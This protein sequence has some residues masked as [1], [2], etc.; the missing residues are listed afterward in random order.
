MDPLTLDAFVPD[1]L[2]RR[3]AGSR[4]PNGPVLERFQAAL[5][6]ADLSGFSTLSEGLARRGPR[7]AED[8]KDLLNRFFGRLVD[9]VHGHGGQVLTFPG[10]AVLALWPA[11]DGDVS[12]AA[13]I[14]VGCALEAQAAMDQ[15][16]EPD[17]RLQMRAG[18]GAG[19]VW[20][21][22]LGG[23]E[24][25]WELLVAGNA[26]AEALHAISAVHPGEVAVSAALHE[27]LALFARAAR[28]SDAAFRVSSISAPARR[29]TADS[30]PLVRLGSP[31]LR[32]Y[33][34]RSVQA[35]LDAGQTD[36]LGEFRRVSVL[37]IKLGT[38]D[39]GAVDAIEHLQRVVVSVQTVVYRYGGAIN[40]LLA[41]DNGIVIVSGWGFALHAHVDD[42]VRAV[43]TALDLR[44]DLAEIGVTASFGLATGEVFTGLRGNR[45]RC[46]YAMIGDVVNVAARLMQMAEDGDILCDLLSCE[47]AS[48]RIEFEALVPVRVKGREQAVGAYRPIQLTAGGP[49]EIVGRVE[50]RRALRERL[51]ALV[52][53]S[54]GSVVIIEGD[55]GIGK[56]RVV[57]DLVERAVARGVRTVVA[58]GDEIERSTPYH[59]WR[60]LFEK[61]LGVADLVGRAGLEQ[62]VLDHLQSETRLMPFAALLNPVLRLQLPETEWSERV[63]PR[64]RAHLTRDLLVHLF[65]CTTQG[66]ATLLV[67]EDAHW[68]DSASWALA[69]GIENALP[70]ILLAIAV[71][72]VAQAEKPPEL[73]RLGRRQNAMVLRLDGLA[74]DEMRTLVSQHLRA[75]ILSEPV[76]RLIREKA[77]GHPFFAEELAHALRDRGLV[78][79]DRGECRFTAAAE[80]Q[81]IELPNTVQVVVKSRIDQLSVPQQ[82][83]LKVASVL[84]R[85]FE[86]SSLRAVYPIDVD[87]SQLRDHLQALVDRD[88]VHVSAEEPAPT[89]VFKHA[90]TQEVAYSLLPFALRRQLHAAVA[91]AIEAQHARDVTR[92]YPLLAHH[93]SRAELADKALFYLEK[94]GE[95][96]LGRHASEEASRFFR[97]AIEID[98]KASQTPDE[99]QPGSARRR[100]ASERDARRIRWYRRLG[101]AA[102]N[103]GRWDE[104]RAH[105][106][107]SLALV[108]R[109]LPVSKGGWAVGL[110]AQILR[111]L[112]RRLTP[113]PLQSRQQAPEVLLE[114]VSAYGRIGAIAYH[115]NDGLIPVLYSLIGALNLAERLPPTPEFSLVCADVGNTLGL[116]SLRR[117]AR[118]YHGLATQAAA[119]LDDPGIATR[120]RARMA[121][122]NLGIGNWD[123]CR[124]LDA[125][126][127]LCEQIG[128][129]YVWEENAAIR[130]RAAHLIGEF[131]LA[132]RLGADI[133]TRASATGSNVHE[134]WGFGAEAW[135]VLYLGDAEAALELADRGLQLVAT[136]AHTDRSSMLDLLGVKALAHL[137]RGDMDQAWSAARRA[138]DMITTAPRARYFALM[139]LNGVAEV[140]LAR[141]EGHEISIKSTEAER[142]AWRMSGELDRYARINLSAR[143]RSLL[144]RGSAEWL[145]GR[146]SAAHTTWRQALAEAERFSLQYEI[147]RIHEEIGRRLAPDDASRRQH[148]SQAIEGFRRLNA[149]HDL[150]RAKARLTDSGARSTV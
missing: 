116:A 100:L 64:G 140:C 67:L 35:S 86:L 80:R 89:Y 150:K 82:L 6:L 96:A 71:R 46:E 125:A 42:E 124:H 74:P 56:S 28:L 127:S 15:V 75:R 103:L 141:W 33:V 97:E 5:L 29:G 83:T 48:K 53:G 77:E 95:K 40:Q 102:I 104:G 66:T 93:W 55:A 57:A 14:A 68:F 41:D 98:E 58:G 7:G 13:R 111:Q 65:R 47:G 39:V 52:D 9:M 36:W 134:I 25:R 43:R 90:I 119:Q 128:D 26:L 123:S 112:A 37:F 147:A 117:L 115:L 49:S 62:R 122:Y 137:R 85:T 145:T 109:P 45:Q 19:E 106:E 17:V 79:L 8:L 113:A 126:M 24:G 121:V 50:E 133:R 18:I 16:A 135:G 129:T 92:A 31:L 3:V 114:A 118:I 20:V 23:V 81:P 38:L 146:E 78:E 32:A 139:Y 30:V 21:A 54:R 149:Q 60:V 34:P 144:V 12:L 91:T 108:G 138:I 73:S 105:F 84:G 4:P 143:A 142:W 22:T 51:D 132:A 110:G 88:H 120:I 148:L 131:E 1:L 44:R 72:S 59:P 136:A 107:Q 130:S 94:A 2:R 69:E 101:D 61:L 99:A 63:P 87:A 76:A 70:D 27:R 11:D 10:D